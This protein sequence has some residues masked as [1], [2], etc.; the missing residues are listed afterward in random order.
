ME[1][2]KEKSP[3]KKAP[4]PAPPSLESSA[5]RFMDAHNSYGKA[6]QDSVTAGMKRYD[7]AYRA[8]VNEMQAINVDM[9]KMFEDAYRDY[10][11]VMQQAS[12]ENDAKVSEG[13]HQHYV[14]SMQNITQ[15]AQ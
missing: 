1:P 14:V 10:V 7:E 5:A 2:S 15:D 6:Q 12:L 13:T 11:R 9:Q 8:Y 4:S 3:Q